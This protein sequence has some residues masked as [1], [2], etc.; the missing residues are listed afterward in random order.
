MTMESDDS[1]R[2]ERQRILDMVQ[3]GAVSPEEA[4]RLLESLEQ[5]GKARQRCPYC[6]EEIPA[7]VALCPECNSSL[8][9]QSAASG[10][11]RSGTG[12][13]SLSSLGKF[14]VCYTL[15]ICGI[16]LV[17]A[18]AHCS[19][20]TVSGMILAALG[21]ASGILMCK[22]SAAGWWLGA[23]WGGI[24]ILPVVV[25]NTVLNRQVLHLGVLSTTNGSGF[26]VN[27]VGIV[28]LVLF[29]KDRPRAGNQSDRAAG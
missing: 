10:L 20:A 11:Q 14:L 21:I 17:F 24:Q 1:Q 27:A 29:L 3:S 25:A 22:G 5:R 13:H 6:A 12:F 9:G 2:S 23:L 16:V 26:G 19:P 18:I 8:G 7:G 28:L 4:D 15:L